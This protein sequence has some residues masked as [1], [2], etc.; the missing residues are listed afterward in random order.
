MKAYHVRIAWHEPYEGSNYY[1]LRVFAD[2]D[3]AQ[4]FVEYLNDMQKRMYDLVTG[5]G[6]YRQSRTIEGHANHA[7]R[8]VYNEKQ[9]KKA[10]KL[11]EALVAIYDKMTSET[12]YV[13]SADYLPNSI[14]NIYVSYGILYY[15]Y[16]VNGG[17]PE[18]EME[19]VEFI[20]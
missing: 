6:D 19:E 9:K 7:A 13:V 14:D 4:F 3:E 8:G 2:K 20:S 16:D 5:T 15:N 1:T 18:I 10:A 12:G 17:E 11:H